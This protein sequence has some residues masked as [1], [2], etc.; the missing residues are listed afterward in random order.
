LLTALGCRNWSPRWLILLTV[1]SVV[2]YV[3]GVVAFSAFY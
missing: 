1:I 2:H 3:I